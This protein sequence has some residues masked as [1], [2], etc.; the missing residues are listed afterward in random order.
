MNRDIKYKVWVGSN[1]V[2]ANLRTPDSIR[3]LM[4]PLQ[5]PYEYHPHS[6]GAGGFGFLKFYDEESRLHMYGFVET[7]TVH[8]QSV[9]FGFKLLLFA[10][11]MILLVVVRG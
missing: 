2:H 1:G 4:S 11:T 8:R 3:F 7:Y 9:V 6:L 10:H 5:G